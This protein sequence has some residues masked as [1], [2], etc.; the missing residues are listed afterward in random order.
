MTLRA[1]Y[2]V[3]QAGEDAGSKEGKGVAQSSEIGGLS[4]AKTLA[5]PVYIDHNLPRCSLHPLHL[6]LPPLLVFP[7]ISPKEAA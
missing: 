7:Y 6:L 3:G 5:K 1:A 4:D 2:D